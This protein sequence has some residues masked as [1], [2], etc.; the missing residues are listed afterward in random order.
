MGKLPI[1]SGLGDLL[2]VLDRSHASVLLGWLVGQAMALQGYQTV[3]G[4]PENIT[5]R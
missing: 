4:Y 2:H 1:V 3:S 5:Y